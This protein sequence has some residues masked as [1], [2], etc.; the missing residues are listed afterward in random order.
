MAGMCYHLVHDTCPALFSQFLIMKQSCP[1]WIWTCDSLASSSQVAG[2]KAWSTRLWENL[3]SVVIIFLPRPSRLF[4]P[5]SQASCS[6][7]FHCVFMLFAIL[8]APYQAALWQ[9]LKAGSA[10]QWGTEVHPHPS[11]PVLCVWTPRTSHKR[12]HCLA[13]VLRRS[14][15]VSGC[16]LISEGCVCVGVGEPLRL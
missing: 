15:V 13:Y 6:F 9:G 1:G 10:Q 7:I 16:K 2:W 5:F 4:D 11:V 8:M 14:F 3:C 12:D